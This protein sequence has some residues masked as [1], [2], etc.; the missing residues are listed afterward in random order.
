MIVDPRNSSNS[1]NRLPRRRV[2]LVDFIWTRDRDPRVPLGQ[3]S[4]HAALAQEPACEVRTMTFPVNGRA[5]TAHEIAAEILDQV[6]NRP[7]DQV[8]I[9]LGV[10]VWGENLIQQVLPL[11]RQRGFRGRI[12]LGGPQISYSGPGIDRVYPDADVFVRGYGEDALRILARTSGQPAL[13]GVHYAAQPDL[14]QQAEVDLA[15]LPSPLLKFGSEVISAERARWETERGCPFRCAFCQHREAGARLRQR[16]FSEARISREIEVLCES[17]PAKLSVLD[18]IFDTGP[19]GAAILERL[20]R[21]GFRGQVSLQCRPEMTTA[22]FLREASKLDV[23]LEFGLQTIHDLEGRAIN[24]RNNME[25]VGATLTRVHAAG[26]NH[27]VSL[28]YGLPHQT[29]ASFKESVRWCLERRIPVIKAFPL[30]LLRGTGLD[31]D[32]DR[33]GLVEDGQAMPRVIASSSF[34]TSDWNEM[35]KIFAALESTEGHHPSNLRSLLEVAST[36]RPT[37][38]RWQPV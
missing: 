37:S 21:G 9:A 11:L 6:A 36:M 19:R 29:L 4:L 12:I 38:S 7:A 33:W 20:A 30:M 31:Q 13:T 16:H 10:Y 35:D 8:D 26:L 2:V 32:R 22:D 17:Q 24:R 5:R 1:G 15:A 28:I 3:A 23:F 27:M 14:A 18:P 25:R 34:T